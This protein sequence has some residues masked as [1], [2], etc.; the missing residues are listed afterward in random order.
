MNRRTSPFVPTATGSCSGPVPARQAALLYGWSKMAKPW[1]RGATPNVGM[2]PSTV[3][4]SRLSHASKPVRLKMSTASY[5]PAAI[6]LATF[7]VNV[8]T[9]RSTT[10]MSVAVALP[11]GTAGSPG[12]ARPTKTDSPWIVW[13]S[14]SGVV[15]L[16]WLATMSVASSTFR[17]LTTNGAKSSSAPMK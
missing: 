3:M 13:P 12:H 6:T 1:L 11:A 14:A 10:A 16:P 4:P 7:S 8:Q 9:P 15:L 17:P 2:S 5:P